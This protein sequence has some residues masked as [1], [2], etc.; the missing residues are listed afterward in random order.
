MTD[1]IDFTWLDQTVYKCTKCDYKG[2]AFI[3]FKLDGHGEFTACFCCYVNWVKA[4]VPEA[5]VVSDD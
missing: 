5:K 1:H 4:N 3:N 2:T